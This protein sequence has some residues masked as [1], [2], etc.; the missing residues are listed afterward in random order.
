MTRRSP[1]IVAVVVL[2]VS[3]ALAQ[4]AGYG[5]NSRVR[6]PHGPVFNPTLTPEWKEAGGNPLIYQQ[7]MREKLAIAQQKAM[8]KQ[9]QAMQKQ[10][11]AMQK[12]QAAF[13]KWYT[14]QAEKKEKGEETDPAFEAMFGD[15]AAEA[16]AKGASPPR[17]KA[18]FRAAMRKK[19]EAKR[20]G[21]D[22]GTAEGTDGTKASADGPETG[23]A[24]EVVG[25]VESP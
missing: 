23:A 10:A 13:T 5:P 15:K 4:R 11:Q 22:G 1:L 20:A 16:K 21:L 17:T 8:Q 7:I 14:E 2:I 3:P 19:A 9:Y 6:S 24:A 12:Q 18:Q 25:E